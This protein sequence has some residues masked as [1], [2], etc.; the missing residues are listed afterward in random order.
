MREEGGKWREERGGER[1]AEWRRQEEG[2]E[3]KEGEGG[4]RWREWLL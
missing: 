2:G 4:K 3:R 1:K